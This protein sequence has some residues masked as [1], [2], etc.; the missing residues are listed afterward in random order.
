MNKY[1]V[2]IYVKDCITLQSGWDIEI[3]TIEADSES[4][5]I[6]LVELLPFFDKV[7]QVSQIC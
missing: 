6:R 2:E 1:L 4:L 7:I 5:A 3:I